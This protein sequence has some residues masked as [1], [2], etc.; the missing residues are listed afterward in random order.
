MHYENLVLSRLDPSLEGDFDKMVSQ[1]P[2]SG[3]HQSMVWAKVCGFEGLEPEVW[4]LSKNA[5]VFA[6]A[7]FLTVGE[8]EDFYLYCPD[9]PILDWTLPDSFELM[10]YFFKQILKEKKLSSVM[11]KPRLL[12]GKLPF[13]KRYKKFR[14]DLLSKASRVI[15]LDASLDELFASMRG[16]GRRM[17]RIAEKNE[18]LVSSHADL[19]SVR[20]FYSVYSESA[21]RNQFT[22]KSFESIDLLCKELFQ[23]RQGFI[24]LAHFEGEVA[25]AAIVTHYG[26]VASYF[27]AGTSEKNHDS[28]AIF[29]LIWMAI[30]DAKKAGLQ[31]FDFGG[32]TLEE[33]NTWSG[34]SS[35]KEKFGGRIVD[36][37]GK[38]I[39]EA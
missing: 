5:E 22:P 12:A 20:D 26:S 34:F 13:A 3:F 11:F 25:A 27:L 29:L 17:V 21:A 7:L 9:G 32:I 36:F 33:N 23:A 14:G 39:F 30:Q 1:T 8:G 37:E 38:Y 18:V 28:R 35:F 15:D 16:S 2:S 10:E 24:Y 19:A 4:V 31:L 6:S